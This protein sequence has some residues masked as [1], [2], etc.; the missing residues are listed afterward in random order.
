MYSC[1]Q[2]YIVYTVRQTGSLPLQQVTSGER[3]SLVSA[4]AAGGVFVCWWV[5]SGV[6]FVLPVGLVMECLCAGG[7]VFVCC[8]CSLFLRLV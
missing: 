5:S 2:W 6:V 8:G 4:G 1:G 7:V 3:Y